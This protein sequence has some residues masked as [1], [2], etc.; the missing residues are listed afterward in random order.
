MINLLYYGE[1]RSIA[2]I[3]WRVEILHKGL[4]SAIDSVQ[5]TFPS[6][7]PLVF[8]WSEL[9]T[10]EVIQGSRAT[11]TVVSETDR[12]FL[13][14]Y[15][16]DVGTIFLKVYREGEFYWTGALD[17]EL[18]EEP[19]S[20]KHNYDVRFTFSDFA[21]L[22]RLNYTSHTNRKITD[23]IN[24]CI[25]AAG[26]EENK[27]RFLMST[28]KNGKT[29]QQL[30]ENL[31]VMSGNFYNE[32]GEA[33]TLKEVLEETLKPFSLRV[34]QKNGTIFIYDLNALFELPAT[35][36]KWCDTDAILGVNKIYN[37][38][39]IVY[40]QYAQKA[41]VQGNVE[42]D[43]VG[44][45]LTK[46]VFTTNTPEEPPGVHEFDVRL[47]TAGKIRGVQVQPITSTGAMFL[48][49]VPDYSGSSDAC[50]AW[51][52]DLSGI[53]PD[54]NKLQ[55]VLTAE[56]AVNRVPLLIAR[57]NA[58]FVYTKGVSGRIKISLE[59]M[60]DIRH[61]PFS[62]KEWDDGIFKTYANTSYIKC[63]LFLKNENN[64]IVGYYDNSPFFKNTNINVGWKYVV[65]EKKGNF[66][67]WYYDKRNIFT[68]YGIAGWK[69]NISPYIYWTNGEIWNCLREVDGDLI[70]LPKKSGFLE[71]HVYP[72][73]THLPCKIPHSLS[74]ISERINNLCRYFLFKSINIECDHTGYE[75]ND[76]D[77][78]DDAYIN[79]A[80]KEKIEIKN[81]LGT[82]L[83]L[84][85]FARGCIY[86]KDG[87]CR[88]FT[89]N[90]I[91]AR[92]EHLLINTVYSQHSARKAVLSGS[93][94]LINDYG[95]YCDNSM[96]NVKFTLASEYQNA[97]NDVSEIKIIEFSKDIFKS[98]DETENI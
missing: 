69:K 60:F 79:K 66:A 58:Y 71:L 21:I 42:V 72:G 59:M 70:E 49:F 6:S 43:S 63:D 44:A 84:L 11:L 26:I 32:D 40:S 45:G 56:E 68:G 39:T 78:V 15:T 48:K 2:G 29:G 41:I 38:V 19:Y 46:S 75:I 92:L 36:V 55:N 94:E 86:D 17:S 35:A 13:N 24:E 33:M 9:E 93:A 25:V 57:T 34:L 23:V 98:S 22:D 30:F 5:L 77:I 12:Q 81:I 37:N 28:Y 90:G 64:E 14:L 50:I 4:S 97:M 76:G 7:E 82:P 18:Y 16:I 62:S 96:Q 87:I 54:N 61:N 20:F 53:R 65:P 52:C 85:P 51:R 1:F 73:I 83:Q 8:E 47:S 10:L 3:L 89:R 27:I 80:A 67:L 95:V 74:P 31:Y 88:D 91:T